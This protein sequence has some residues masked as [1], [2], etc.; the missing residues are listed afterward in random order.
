MKML[1]YALSASGKMDMLQQ[2]LKNIKI[3]QQ[4]AAG[5]P[6]GGSGFSKALGFRKNLASTACSAIWPGRLSYPLGHRI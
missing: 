4:N 2:I 5:R 6:G 3:A 1:V